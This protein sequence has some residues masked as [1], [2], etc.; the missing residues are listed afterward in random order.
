MSNQGDDA[1]GP[2]LDPSEAVLK[3]SYGTVGSAGNNLIIGDISDD[4]DDQEILT[5]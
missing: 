5:A 2:L 1:H 3:T 4:E